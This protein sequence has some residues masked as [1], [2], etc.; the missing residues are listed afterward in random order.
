MSNVP[1]S[2]WYVEVEHPGSG[3]V[4]TPTV[5]D[6]RARIAPAPFDY[7]RAYIPVRANEMWRGTDFERAPMRIWK[8]GQ[9]QPIEELVAVEDG[10]RGTT[11]LVGLGGRELDERVDEQFDTIPVYEAAEQIIS[12]Y[13]SYTVNVDAPST[14]T[15]TL[16]VSS[17]DTEADWSNE[18]DTTDPASPII[19]TSNLSHGDG[20]GSTLAQT[21]F[22][23]EA[24]DVS[25]AQVEATL[26]GQSNASGAEAVNLEVAGNYVDTGATLE[27]TIPESEV[28]LTFRFQAPNN[29]ANIT[30][31]GG[32]YVLPGIRIQIDGT[33][34]YEL[35]PYTRTAS[36]GYDWRTISVDWS[37]G[38]LA[39]GNHDIYFEVTD[40][41]S[42]EPVYGDWFNNTSNFD[43]DT[44]NYRDQDEA[45]VAV[46]ASG[47]GGNKAFSPAAIWVDNGTT[48]N[49]NWAD[50]TEAHN[51]VEE[52]GV[53]D[54]GALVTSDSYTYSHT[55]NT[56]GVYRYRC[57]NHDSDGMRGAIV[58]GTDYESV[59][60][61]ELYLDGI[62]LYDERWHSVGGFSDSTNSNDALAYPAN[63]PVGNGGMP[64]PL[65]AFDDVNRVRAITG[66][67]ISVNV[68]DA[69]GI[70]RL[71]LSNDRGPPYS[72]S[73][74]GVSSYSTDFGDYGEVIRWRLG[75]QGYG[76][77][78]STTPTEGYK[79][80]EIDSWQL[81]ADLEDIP[82]LV[83]QYYDGSA[84]SALNEIAQQYGDAL[85]A[86]NT[87][88]NGNLSFEWAEPG[89]RTT[90]RDAPVLDYSTTKTVEDAVEKVTI[91]GSKQVSRGEQVTANHGSWIQLSETDVLLGQE[92]VVDES[93][94]EEYTYRTDY[95]LDVSD[96]RIKT[97]QNGNI[98]DGQALSVDY[99]YKPSGSYTVSGAGNDP[100]EIKRELPN[101]P[102]DR[103]CGQVARLL[104][105]D[106]SDPLYEATV[107]LPPDAS[108]WSVV[109]AINLDQLPYDALEPRDTEETPSGVRLRLGSRDS[110]A[111]RIGQVRQ[112][113]GSVSQRS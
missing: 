52:N 32:E 91:K 100:R 55:F 65:R 42:G 106:L 12:N 110:A 29:L 71:E 70:E 34:Y 86:L 107:D 28:G 33:T 84:K 96:G 77:R 2:G 108:D 102:T 22:W 112:L 79:R 24:E 60:N 19:S 101:L 5:Y 73:S 80:P 66:G 26:T 38:D 92:S 9:R 30:D 97:L 1:A 64:T 10:P 113:L 45:D 76:S 35:N 99:W 21:S 53:F 82:L 74:A 23:K 44:L 4:W 8:D 57:E 17:G 48:V 103:A 72:S 94:S 95:D 20:Q 37:G 62:V 47:N 81:D 14:T 105:E 31:A 56:D 39:P 85:W 89:Q 3:Y 49:F 67:A 25:T 98:P 59:Q 87:D 50:D 88:A 11:T 63:Y 104:A 41:A 18:F 36:T 78:T 13:T 46:G 90:D 75:L 6:D 109:E 61:A 58:V 83:D 40:T 51:V 16:T 7:K 27:H 111:E 68:D 54:S 69:A 15:E 43:G 93:T